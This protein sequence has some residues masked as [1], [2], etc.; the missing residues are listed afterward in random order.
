MVSGGARPGV[1]ARLRHRQTNRVLLVV[2]VD[3]SA[4]AAA[5]TPQQ[6]PRRVLT[7]L[8]PGDDFTR[9]RENFDSAVEAVQ[10][11]SHCAVTHCLPGRLQAI[12]EA[13]Q[14]I[15]NARARRRERDN[16]DRLILCGSLSEARLLT[17]GL[18]GGLSE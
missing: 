18:H 12:C 3:W 5:T 11:A 9:Q 15:P 13:A 6:L 17:G 2:N 1:A 16:D 7:F 8:P 10:Q 14:L 4:G